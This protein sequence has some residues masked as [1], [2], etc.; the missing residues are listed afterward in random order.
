[1]RMIAQ[2]F[3]V[4]TLFAAQQIWAGDAPVNGEEAVKEAHKEMPWCDE[5]TLG[6]AGVTC[7]MADPQGHLPQGKDPH[8]PHCPDAKTPHEVWIYDERGQQQFFLGCW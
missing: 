6:E 1:M 2:I 7:K 3:A 5:I 8:G 4:M